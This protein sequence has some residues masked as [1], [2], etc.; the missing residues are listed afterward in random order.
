[1]EESS[2]GWYQG[3]SKHHLEMMW[4]RISHLLKERVGGL[5]YERWLADLQLLSLQGGKVVFE[6]PSIMH[7]CWI[8]DN[9]MPVLDGVLH[10]V[11][12]TR[13]EVE[14][15]AAEAKDRRS[16]PMP[17]MEAARSME[18]APVVKEVV[19]LTAGPLFQGDQRLLKSIST[20]GI[21]HRN[22]FDTFVEGPNCSYS[23]AVA[24]AVAEKPGKTYNPLFLHGPVGLGKTHLMQAIGQEILRTKSRKVVRYVTSES[25]TNE[26]IDAL[27]HGSV[28]DFRKKYRKVD[29]LLIDDIQFFAG[30]GS[31]Q[32][33]FFHTFNDLFNNFKQIVLTSDRAPSEIRNL[34][35][36]LV[37][38]FEWGM[39]TQIE[40]PDLETRMAILK[41]KTSYWSVPVED[42]VLTFLAENIRTNI[43]RL[44]GAL[45]RVAA[46][47]S[48]NTGKPLTPP[49]L[50]GLLRD[51]LEE[52]DA[53]NITIDWIQKVVAEHFDVRL[54]DMTGKRRPANIAGPR[55]LAMYLAR[56]LTKS[57]LVE[58][59][60]AFGGRDHGTVIHACKA[61]V[62]RLE[63]EEFRRLVGQLTEKIKRIG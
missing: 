55:Q 35:S 2:A 15:V 26:Y 29:V 8:L 51:I 44:E 22:S 11:L 39:A 25:F 21:N 34:E 32:E 30:K 23:Y 3:G 10:E 42:W 58:I 57:S 24:R 49:V 36:R 38:R 62:K 6:V 45:M 43:R 5:L 60:E 16:S 59:G 48:L 52:A 41:Q 63:Q 33:E 61:V 28:T 54:A 40:S 31:T 27:R 46:H 47:V 17:V 37:S 53:K 13:C 19:E 20:A 56:E 14:F 12:G 18:S 50:E 7:E 1:M 9:F 4:E